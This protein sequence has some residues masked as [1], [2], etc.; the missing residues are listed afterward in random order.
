MA[1]PNSEIT[2]TIIKPSCIEDSNRSC[3]TTPPIRIPANQLG[4]GKIGSVKMLVPGIGTP[5]KTPTMVRIT[6]MKAPIFSE[7]QKLRAHGA[8]AANRQT[9]IVAAAIDEPAS[10]E[11]FALITVQIIISDQ[12]HQVSGCNDFI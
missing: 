12:I 8:S 9:K 10:Q 4:S 2:A 3:V 7:N 11:L 5:I 1:A 6:R